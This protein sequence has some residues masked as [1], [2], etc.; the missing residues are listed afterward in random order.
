MK[1]TALLI[2]M[3]VLLAA[4]TSGKTEFFPSQGYSADAAEV[5]VIR[6]RRMFGMGFSMKVLLDDEVI[7]RLKTGQYVTFYV[8][9]GI[10][11][12][13]IPDSSITVALERA[14][15]HYFAILTDSSQFGFEIERINERK[16]TSWM[17]N[18]RSIN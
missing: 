12:I 15:K 5:T 10:H 13:G 8:N 11:T 16:A 6:E 7:A 3:F 1:R 2:F 18:A 4:C 9:P 14:R 17:A